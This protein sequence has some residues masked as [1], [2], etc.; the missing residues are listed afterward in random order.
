M[1]APKSGF[2]EVFVISVKNHT[3]AHHDT[4]ANWIK[5]ILA[6]AGVDTGTYSAHSCRAASTTKA[7]LAGVSL[8]TIIKSAS[9]SNVT[10][11]KE[12][13]FKEIKE[14][15]DLFKPNFGEQ[16][17]DSFSNSTGM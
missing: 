6:C 4:I 14:H 2:D 7:A 10:T 17:L 12:Y 8:S 13:Y 3:P 11:F 15:F 9:W 5:N 16:L 1:R